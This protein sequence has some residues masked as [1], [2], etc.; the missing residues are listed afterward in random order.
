MSQ[1]SNL[2][3]LAGRIPAIRQQFMAQYGIRSPSS[4]AKSPSL[5]DA[6][7][8]P[9]EVRLQISTALSPSDVV[10][11]RR[12]SFES[13]D[14]GEQVVPRPACESTPSHRHDS[15]SKASQVSSSRPRSRGP[16][17]FYQATSACD[18]HTDATNSDTAANSHSPIA[19]VQWPDQLS[20]GTLAHGHRDLS[21]VDLIPRGT[22][23]GL[24]Q[25]TSQDLGTTKYVLD[26]FLTDDLSWIV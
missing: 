11:P 24:D 19:P 13:Q 2:E 22:L 20:A 4:V 18:S 23:W 8:L 21:T 15:I 12:L 3:D 16:N 26:D 6:R 14:P 9:D 25:D 10:D 5:S 7:T 1:S 17:S